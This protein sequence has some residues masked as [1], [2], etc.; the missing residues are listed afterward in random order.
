L[1]LRLAPTAKPNEDV[2]APDLLPGVWGIR[3]ENAVANGNPPVEPLHHGAK[4]MGDN[5][6]GQLEKLK[7]CDTNTLPGM[8]IVASS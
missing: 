5:D 7:R 8:A 2:S 1:T 6:L 3:T 4:M